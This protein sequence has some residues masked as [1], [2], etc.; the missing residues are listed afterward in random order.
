[1]SISCWLSG[2]SDTCSEVRSLEEIM[3]TIGKN[4]VDDEVE[5]DNIR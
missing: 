4:N 1:M 3:D 5:D 2:E